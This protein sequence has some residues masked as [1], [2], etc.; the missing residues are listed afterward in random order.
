MRRK[1]KK[2]RESEKIVK[3]VQKMKEVKSGEY[4]TELFAKRRNW[5]LEKIAYVAKVNLFMR[6]RN[7]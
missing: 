5:F 4:P 6:R 3:I 1:Y 2:S 7:D